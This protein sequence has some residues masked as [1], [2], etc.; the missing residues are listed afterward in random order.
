MICARSVIAVLLVGSAIH[1]EQLPREFTITPTEIKE[2]PPYVAT[3]V[4]PDAICAAVNDAAS[5]LVVGRRG[6][7]E[8]E[9][10]LAVFRLGADGKIAG[11]PAWITLP[12]PERLAAKANYPLGLLFH[13]KLPLL[14]VWQ[15]IDALPRANQIKH[16]DFTDYLEFDHLLVYAIKNGALELVHSGAN[17]LGFR[18]G[19]T[20]GTVGFDYGAK[21]L[22]VPNVTGEA[23]N[24]AAIAFYA[25]DGEGMPGETPEETSEQPGAKKVKNLTLSKS[26]KVNR[27]VL[28]PKKLKTSRYYPSGTGWYA[29]SEALI[30]GGVSG[31]MMTDF[32][33]GALRQTWIGIPVYTGPCVIAAHPTL[34]AIYLCLQDHHRFYAFAQVNGYVTMLPQEAVVT[35]GHLTGTPVVLAKHSRLAVGGTKSLHFLGLDAMGKLDGK[36]EKLALPCAIVKGLAYSEKHDRLFVAVDKAN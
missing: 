36:G 19:L 32:H 1:A 7:D 30:M 9:K 18:C 13:P 25:L 2:A 27:P 3:V 21:N 26:G 23:E 33:N 8:P 4:V 10:H 15:D 31:C 11:E 6:K 12:K 22:F 17:G 24:D 20:S 14:Y 28:L 16:P 29:G 5:L 34:P 35:G